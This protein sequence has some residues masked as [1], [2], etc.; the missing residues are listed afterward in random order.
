MNL[1][2]LNLNLLI[3]LDSLLLEGSVTLA[4]KKLFIT[5]AAM[6]NNLQQLRKIFQDELLVREKN[7]MVLTTYAK[8]LQPRLHQILQEV[9]SLVVSGH[10]FDP[11]TSERTI[12]I[13]M[14]DYMAS[15]LLPKLLLRLQKLAPNIK[16]ITTTV[17]QLRNVEPFENGDYELGIG[18]L[19][20]P[21]DQ[22]RTDLLFKDTGVCI[23][24][25]KHKLAKKK[26]ITLEDYLAG[27]HVAVRADNP[28][29][30]PVIEQTLAK[31]GYQRDIRI[32][33]PFINPIFR[34]IEESDE[35]VGTV[36]EK[37][38]LLYKNN[39]NFLIKPLPF[40]VPNIEFFLVWHKRYDNDPG[41]QWLR[42]QIKALFEVYPA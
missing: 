16:L 2:R 39:H 12:K 38:A 10:R 29:V 18:K 11:A 23:I 17:Y 9:H 25:P 3:A 27:K 1:Y 34:I 32:G 6:S 4:A 40:E 35:L 15:L 41:H 36:I 7:H 24:N 33:L 8:E 22:L 28:L 42:E 19:F 13:G 30:T 14:S 31:L 5:Q 26:K 21:A 37:M 20:A